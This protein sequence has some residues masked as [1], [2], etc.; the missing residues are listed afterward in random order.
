MLCTTLGDKTGLRYSLP[1]EAQWEYACR[2]GTTTR[3]HF[4]ETIFGDDANFFN[5]PGPHVRRGRPT[6]VGTFPPNAWGLHDM[7]G[8]LLEWCSDRYGDCEAAETRDPEGPGEGRLRVLRG[9][10]WE[11][12]ANECRSARRSGGHPTNKWADSG[13]RIVL[14]LD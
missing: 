12:D 7:H 1:T 5:P 3:F 8:N 11:D 2:S 10:S 4:G 9:G 14:R 13:C 6:P